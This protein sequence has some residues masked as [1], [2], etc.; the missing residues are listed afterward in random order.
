MIGYLEDVLIGSITIFAATL[1][2]IS[3]ISYKRTANRKLLYVSLAF[4]VFFIKGLILSF[5]LYYPKILRI[6]ADLYTI[7]PDILILAFL[8]LSIMRR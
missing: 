6:E 4:F 8:Y 1:L 5:S 7:L 3:Y 2:I